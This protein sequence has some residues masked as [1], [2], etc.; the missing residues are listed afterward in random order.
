MKD[1]AFIFDVEGTLIDCV[2][3]VLACWQRTFAKHGYDF[4]TEQLHRYSGMDGHLMLKA[5]APRLS[6]SAQNAMLKEQG[7][8]Y[9]QDFIH[10]A[11]ALPGAGELIETLQHGGHSLA[12]ATTCQPDEWN[13]Y[14]T[15]IPPAKKINVSICGDEVKQE[16]PAP[17]LIRAAMKKLPAPAQRIVAVGDT[18]YDAQAARAAGVEAIGVLTGGFSPADLKEAGCS[19]IAA[20]P[21]D[22]LRLVT[23][24]ASP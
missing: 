10:R 3:L 22:L 16:K 7:E 15:L 6:S 14:L 20:D 18:P 8:R 1:T 9:R 2:P 24:A 19:A 11:R 17:D 5:L 4:S 13:H 21:A 23:A 12:V